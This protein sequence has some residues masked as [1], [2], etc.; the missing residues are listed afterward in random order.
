MQ[1]IQQGTV[2]NE[3]A[4]ESIWLMVEAIGG[5]YTTLDGRHWNKVS[6]YD[7]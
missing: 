7:F 6:S 3:I 1:V 5:Q 2:P 4:L